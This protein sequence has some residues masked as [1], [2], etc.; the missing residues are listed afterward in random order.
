MTPPRVPRF[1][2]GFKPLLRA[3]NLAALHLHLPH[4]H[5]IQHK[6]CPEEGWINPC[7]LSKDVTLTPHEEHHHPPVAASGSE[8]VNALY[9]RI[10]ELEL[11]NKRLKDQ[12][13]RVNNKWG[14]N[15]SPPPVLSTYEE[16]EANDEMD[17]N[18]SNSSTESFRKVDEPPV[19]P[20]N[21]S[22][23]SAAPPDLGATASL[24]G[25]SAPP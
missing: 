1:G 7:R 6:R 3:D 23:S 20:A 14:E 12:V 19:S 17:D 10:L 8:L 13:E 21:V 18:K 25:A 24:T 15:R 4:A 16:G 11:E 9:R 22:G 5:A 2:P